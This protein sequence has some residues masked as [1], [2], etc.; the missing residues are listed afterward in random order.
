MARRVDG[1]QCRWRWHQHLRGG[2]AGE[3]VL[4]SSL[5]QLQ[6]ALESGLEQGWDG[7][8]GHGMELGLGGCCY[9]ERGAAGGEVA[10]R[11][12]EV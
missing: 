4:S 11:T 12:V 2:A 9:A 10:V 6:L 8:R 1:W 7:V 3:R 5:T